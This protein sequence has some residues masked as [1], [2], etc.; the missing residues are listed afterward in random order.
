[1]KQ[2]LLKDSTQGWINVVCAILTITTMMLAFMNETCV[3]EWLAISGLVSV[4]VFLI[5]N[6][7][8][9]TALNER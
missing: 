2:F 4:I 9:S 7:W 8:V 1:M 5:Y 6:I 3:P